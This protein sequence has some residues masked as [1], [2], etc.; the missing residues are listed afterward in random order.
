M[1]VSSL[2]ADVIMT[3]I[4]KGSQVLLPDSDVLQ[5]AT[6]IIENDTGKIVKVHRQ[7]LA[8]DSLPSPHILIDVGSKMILP[9]LVE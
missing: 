6:I 8:E 2:P 9:G 5:P 4:I 1:E 3:T 7:L